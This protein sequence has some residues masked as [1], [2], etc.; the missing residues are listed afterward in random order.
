MVALAFLW[1]IASAHQEV[2]RL[3]KD[4]SLTGQQLL[5]LDKAL[6]EFNKSGLDAGCW[7]L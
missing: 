3:D 5:V 7:W 2:S 4:V 1:P 6:D